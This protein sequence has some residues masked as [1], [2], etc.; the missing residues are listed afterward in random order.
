[1][2][3]VQEQLPV[4]PQHKMPTVLAMQDKMRMEEAVASVELVLLPEVLG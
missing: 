3:E 2:A 4:A 1:V